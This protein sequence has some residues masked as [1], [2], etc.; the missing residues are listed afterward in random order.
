MRNNVRDGR[1]IEANPQ[2]QKLYAR[3]QIPLTE[4]KCNFCNK[5]AVEDKIHFLIDCDLY[6][7]LRYDLFNEGQKDYSS[8]NMLN[9]DE[10]IIFYEN[11]KLQPI[12]ANTIHKMFY[13]RKFIVQIYDVLDS[14]MIFCIHLKL[15][16]QII[17]NIQC[18]ISQ[19]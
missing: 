17:S 15:T 1:N 9:N 16:K 14:F 2:P 13:R 4:R 8:Y 12:L 3:P 18:L 10:K 6:S 19:I 11:D 5:Q 7:D